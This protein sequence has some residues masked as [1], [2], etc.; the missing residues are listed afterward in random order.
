MY[1]VIFLLTLALI[2]IIAA[3]IQDLKTKEIPNWI[4]FSLIII[5]LGFRFFYSLFSNNDFNFFYQGLIGFAIFFALANLLY[6]GRLFAGGDAKLMMALGPILPLSGILLD[7]LKLLVVFLFS[8]LIIGGIYGLLSSFIVSLRNFNGFRKEFGKLFKKNKRPLLWWLVGVIILAILI[9]ISN[10]FVL[11]SLVIVL[12]VLPYLYIYAKAV[13]ESCMIEKVKV[14][15]LREGD[16]LYKDIKIGKKIIKADWSGL[17]KKDIMSIRRNKKFVKIKQGIPYS[18]VFLFSFIA[19]IYLWQTGLW[20][21][22]GL[23]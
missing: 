4:N 10:E 19:F 12:F 7:N 20:K 17:S 2:W 22:F 15:D 21:N 8:F 6:Y 16:W 9:F 14:K 23:I 18:P 5:A 13:E 1:E 11:F 3:T